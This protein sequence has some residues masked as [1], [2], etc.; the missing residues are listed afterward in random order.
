VKHQCT[1]FHSRL[2]TVRIPQKA[3]RDTL[4]RTCVIALGGICG[5]SCTFWCIW[6]MKYQRNIF[7]A[8]LCPVW[9]Q[10]IACLIRY[11]EHLFLHPMRSMGH[12]ARFGGS[13]VRNIDAIFFIP[14]WAKR[15]YHK[16]V[17]GH[18]T[19]NL[20]FCVPIQS[21]SE[22]STHYF[23]CLGGPDVVSTKCTSGHI[24]LNLCFCIRWDLRVMYCVPVCLWHEISTH[25]F[26]CSGEPSAV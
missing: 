10:Q 21:R 19:P 5:S 14:G 8:R 16:S 17:P 4:R 2:G 24:T 7:H 1:I 11:T 12:V 26:S 18:V 6:G 9:I 23:S 3:C 15:E 25:Y 20:C 13:E 22:M